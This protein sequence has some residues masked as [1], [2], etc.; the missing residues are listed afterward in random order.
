MGCIWSSD[1]PPGTGSPSGIANTRGD[2]FSSW[3]KEK[4]KE[5]DSKVNNFFDLPGESFVISEAEENENNGS[6]TKETTKV[7]IGR[8]S[9]GNKL[10][11]QYALIKNLGAGA[12][13]KVKLCVDVLDEKFYAIKVCH[14]GVLRRRRIG[15][16][17][18]LQVRILG[19][20]LGF[21]IKLNIGCCQ[22]DCD[23]ETIG[24]SK[25]CS[26]I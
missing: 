24:S 25:C 21:I 7:N 8:N 10:V 1:L 19:E 23:Y 6:L 5:N 12:Y 18:A 13:G 17:T 11:N 14:K 20:I 22:R 26:I 15:M 3:A 16:S 4:N 9:H 2:F